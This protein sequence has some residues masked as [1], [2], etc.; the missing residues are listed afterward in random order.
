ATGRRLCEFAQGAPMISQ[1]AFSPDGQYFVCAARNRLVLWSLETHG[2]V[3]A[4]EGPIL[5]A[6]SPDDMRMAVCRSEPDGSS[7]E[8][9]IWNTETIHQGN[10]E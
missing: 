2:K 9:A 6:F 4:I 1:M 3:G 5:F 7:A 10:A 8:V